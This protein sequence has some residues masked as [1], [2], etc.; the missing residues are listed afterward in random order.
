MTRPAARRLPVRAATSAGG[1]VYRRRGAR[2]EVVLVGRA[3]QRLWALPKGTPESAESIE[4]TAL[5]E[6][7][8]ETGL[9][10][11]IA[12]RIGSVRYWFALPQEGVRVRKVVHHF[13]MQPVGGDLTL[14]DGEYDLVTWIDIREATAR[15]S[16]ANERS[17]VERAATLIAAAGADTAPEHRVAQRAP[18]L[19]H[20]VADGLAPGSPVPDNAD[21]AT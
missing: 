20:A 10:V 15:M 18:A 7:R 6:V 11:A 21:A 19:D 5:R 4:Q 8:E 16:Y 12:Q 9:E 3:A 13:L 14:H 1:V 2:V 17:I